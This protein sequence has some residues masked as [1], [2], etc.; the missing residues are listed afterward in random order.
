MHYPI[1][2]VLNWSCAPRQVMFPSLSMVAAAK[3]ATLEKVKALRS[4]LEETIKRNE[5]ADELERIPRE[6][7]LIDE[8]F[9][10]ELIAEG[11]TRVAAAKEVLARDT[12]YTDYLG[13]K[14]KKECWDTMA[15]HGL[16]LIHI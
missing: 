15:T 10:D 12:L 7:L 16:S 6:G 5:D 8:K 13:A 2:F 9:R 1:T 4:K 3:A 11:D 14:I